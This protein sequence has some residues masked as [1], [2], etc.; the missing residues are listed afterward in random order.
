MLAFLGT[1]FGAYAIIGIMLLSI[2]GGL[3]FYLRSTA[4]TIVGLRQQIT[5]LS[6]QTTQLQEANDALKDDVANVVAAQ[7]IVNN[8]L[9]DIRQQAVAASLAVRTQKFTSGPAAQ[10]QVNKATA[11]FFKQLEDISRAQ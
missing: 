3:F 10:D 11:D 5:I 7:T 2:G 1:K 6:V 8:S 4:N 9:E